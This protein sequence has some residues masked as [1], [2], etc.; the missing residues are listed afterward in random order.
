MKSRTLTW[1]ITMILF[2]TLALPVR[3]A[4]QGQ[5]Q[6]QPRY[7]VTDLGTLGGAFSNAFGISNKGSVIQA[8]SLYVCQFFG[9]TE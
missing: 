9:N 8:T 4:A 6:Q 3:L 1:F 7:T 5:S 2:V